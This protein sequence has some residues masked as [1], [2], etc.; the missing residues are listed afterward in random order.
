MKILLV[1]D[2]RALI[3]PLQGLLTKRGHNVDM[4]FD[5]LEALELIEKNDYEVAFLDL[6]LPELT[7]L[8]IVERVRKTKP[9]LKT[10]MMTGYPMMRDFLINTIGADDFLQKP[11][12]FEEMEALLK[13][14][15]VKG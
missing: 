8:E 15:A 12:T 13:K 10:V 2:E 3:E 11:F 6:S 1:D 5:G 14:Y 9:A 7:G 4:A